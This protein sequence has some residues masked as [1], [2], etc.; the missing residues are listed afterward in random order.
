[1]LTT[2]AMATLLL[3]LLTVAMEPLQV[4]DKAAD[5]FD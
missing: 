2:A 5:G 1:V 4:D 3:L